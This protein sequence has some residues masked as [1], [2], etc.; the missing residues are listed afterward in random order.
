MDFYFNGFISNTNSCTAN[1][2]N[3]KPVFVV[4]GFVETVN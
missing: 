3:L 4:W 2:R 1:D